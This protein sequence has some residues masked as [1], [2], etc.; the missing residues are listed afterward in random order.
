MLVTHL[1][2][3]FLEMFLEFLSKILARVIFLEATIN[4]NIIDIVRW[5]IFFLFF[6]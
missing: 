3:K 6:L 2:P 4:I 1:N 5:A